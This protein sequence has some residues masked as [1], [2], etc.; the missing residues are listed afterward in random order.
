MSLP[1]LCLALLVTVVSLTAAQPPNIVF[2][3]AD[4]QRA[5]TIAALGNPVIKT[6]NLDRLVKRGV[7]FTR[8]YMQGG[9]QGA[10][11]VPSRAMLLSGRSLAQ[12]DEKLLKHQTWPHAFGAAGYATFAAGKW[13]NGPPSIPKSFQQAKAL[14]VG[15]MANPLKAP[16][17]DMLPTGKLTPSKISPK[18][19]CEEATDETLAFLKSQDGKQPFFSY[20]AFDGPHDPHIVPEGFPID[21]APASIPLPPNFLPQ[22][23]FDN[24]QMVIRDEQL[25]KWPRPEADVKTMLAE[26]YRYISFLDVQV[27]RVLDAVDAS[28]YA[29]NTI[30]VYA[31]DSGVARGSHG[32]IGKQNLYEHSM[33]V[34]LI[35]AGPGIAADKRSEAMCYL[36]DVLPTLGKLCG[37]TTPPGSNGREFAAVLKDPSQSA[38]PFLM[39]GYRSIQKALSDGR[40]K[41]IRYPHV[42]RTQLFDLQ[43]DP[44]ETK[45]LSTLPEHAER[46]KEMLAKLAAEMK[47]D[48]DNDP[49]TAAKILPADWKA[50]SKVPKPGQKGY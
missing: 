20:L 27:G 46:I 26:Y 17:S 2:I 15:G 10:T 21:Y 48:G 34:P 32:L 18:H 42:D 12:I 23:P 44:Y 38:R 25:M 13:H 45:D 16:T 11:C 39:F 9:N 19:L 22:H 29:A 47:A 6:P 24:G 36:F 8:A 7:A 30:I 4:D 1:R 33:R 3:F 40:W 31:A 5:D 41:L 50:P 28:P 14:F 35:V 37:V 49:L 43:A